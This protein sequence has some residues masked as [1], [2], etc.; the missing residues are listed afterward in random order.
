MPGQPPSDASRTEDPRPHP[1]QVQSVSRA[2][3]VLRQF[4]D[5]RSHRISDIAEATGLGQSTV[6]RLVTTLVA[7]NMLE[8]S[9]GGTSYRLGVAA[10]VI[11]RVA[12]DRFVGSRVHHELLA[13]RD[14]IGVGMSFGIPG[15]GAAFVLLRFSADRGDPSPQT[16]LIGGPL[17][18][19]V[20]GKLFLA[21]GAADEEEVG[22]EPFE[23]LAS[24]TITTW[25]ALRE[26]GARTRERGYSVIRDEVV[27]GGSGVAVPVWTADGRVTAA[28]SA[29]GPNRRFDEEFLAF[30]LPRMRRTSERISGRAPSGRGAAEPDRDRAAP[31]PA[32][33]PSAIRGTAAS[34]SRV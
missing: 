33:T 4:Q 3:T 10:A 16:G 17:H 18:A 32:G 2:F 26:D 1:G 6:H 28:I 23:R 9:V 7:E 8:Q 34:S 5:G 27:E 21:F 19:C 29:F 20:L 11:G 12:I 30:I 14:E 22:P 15:S 25:Q 31:Q 13:L 24:G